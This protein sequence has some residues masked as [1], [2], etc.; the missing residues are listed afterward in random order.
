[1]LH[2]IIL[3]LPHCIVTSLGRCFILNIVQNA[4]IPHYLPFHIVYKKPPI[5]L[6][7]V[8]Q[9]TVQLISR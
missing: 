1:M 8:M 4:K 5:Y 2:N 7:C 6:P 3:K 9:S